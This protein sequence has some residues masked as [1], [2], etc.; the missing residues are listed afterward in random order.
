MRTLAAFIRS[1]EE[2]AR[3]ARVVVESDPFERLGLTDAAIMALV[4]EVEI[5][6]DDLPLYLA[7]SRS[8]VG[9]TNFTHLRAAHFD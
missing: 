7:A 6:T 5:L 1:A 3:E 9:V 4:G 2:I 8:G